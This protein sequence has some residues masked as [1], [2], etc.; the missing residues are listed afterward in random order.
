MAESTREVVDRY[1][2]GMNRG[3]IDASC[4]ALHADVVE[5]YPQSGEEFRGRET[6]RTLLRSFEAR[7][8]QAPEMDRV[9]GSEDRWLMTPAFSLVRVTGSG[10]EYTATGR[11]RYAD[12]AESHL[13]QLL[14]M[15][16][17][18]I[19]QVTS[20]FAAPFEAPEWRAPYRSASGERA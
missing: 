12:G 20:Y 11:V 10:D 16:D 15:R 14:R 4:G 2:A 6:I 7:G 8:G 18:K 19:G 13:I 1:V 5:V 3:D 17:G 9:I